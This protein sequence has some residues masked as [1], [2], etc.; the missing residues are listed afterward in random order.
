MSLFSELRRRNVIKVALLYAVASLLILWAVDHAVTGLV[1]PVWT[2]QFVVLLLAIG[3]PVALIFAWVYEITPQGL[4][5][6]VD[7]DQTQSIVYKTGQKLNAAVAVLAV[8]GF[9]ALVGERLLPE[10]ELVRPEPV[11]EIPLRPIYDAAEGAGV[12]KEITSYSMSN[13]LR[14][15]VWPDYDIPNIAMYNFVRAGGRNE[16]PGITGLSHFFEHMMFN[17]TSNL[18]P[19]EFDRIMEA[20]GGANNAYTSKDLTV[21]QN[22]FPRSALNTIFEL[23]GDRLQN[24]AIDPDMV[25]SER[26]V[27]YSERRLSVDND[28]FGRLYEQ[29]LATAFIAHPYQY[30]IIGWPSDIEGWSEEDVESYFQ[31]Y[32]APNNC[33]MV[34]VGAASP[35]EIFQLADRY[36][37]PIP[38]QAPPPPVRTVEPEQF[39]ERRL[40]IE[41]DA[42]TPLLHLA[43]H[44]SSAAAPEAQHMSLLLNILTGGNSSRLHRLLVEEEQI[45]LAIG[46]MQMEG[47]D[48][49]LVYFYLT[50]PPGADVEAVE[51]RMLEELKRVAVEGVT[52]AELRKAQNI[53]LADYWR[54]RSTINGKAAALGQFEMFT[55]SYENLFSLPEDVSAITVEQL[56][57]VAANVFQQRK[58]TVGVLRSQDDAPGTSE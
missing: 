13:G 9:A 11:E 40:L 38:A 43:F 52:N 47:F 2:S 5:K 34:F 39:G 50:L 45:A 35:E 12:P 46:A 37:R 31:T 54:E 49:G 15:I 20:A 17:G 19:G 1:L 6:G 3:L 48:P 25:E 28:N 57:A 58:M 32:Y 33:T 14:I 29:M 55:G 51:L 22:W 23:E 24:L 56:R 18:D 7:V 26:G 36:L 16:Y 30:P 41:T 10:F 42:Q 21:Y 27:M 8:L 44:A 4:K 53:L